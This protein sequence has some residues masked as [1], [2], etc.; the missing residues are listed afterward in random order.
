MRVVSEPEFNLQLRSELLLHDLS[1][2]GAVTGPG[3]SG[4]IAAVYASHML[5][6][7]FIPHGA[8][9]PTELGRLLIVD[10]AMETGKTIRKSRNRYAAARPI[11]RVIAAELMGTP[12]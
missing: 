12:Q 10:T 11:T 5:G 6:V 8:P 2:V 3:R 9:A 4:A 1:E 7:P